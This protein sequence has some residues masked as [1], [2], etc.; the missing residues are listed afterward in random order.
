L[1]LLS[2]GLLFRIAATTGLSEEKQVAYFLGAFF[3]VDLS[4]FFSDRAME[5]F[6]LDFSDFMP[7]VFAQLHLSSF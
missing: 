1:C 5:K 3:R 7:T 2:S 4:T 6:S